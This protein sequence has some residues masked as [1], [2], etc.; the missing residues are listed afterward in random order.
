VDRSQTISYISTL[1]LD[2]ACFILLQLKVEEDYQPDRFW[3]VYN[4]NPSVIEP[5]ITDLEELVEGIYTHPR[6]R[7]VGTEPLFAL[8]SL[9]HMRQFHFLPRD[10]YHLATMRH[11]GV[12]SIVTLD[13]DFLVVPELHIYTC[14]PSIL[15][16]ASRP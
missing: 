6:I 5:Y 16:Q 7:L 8:E 11:Y 14:V 12:D 9:I 15:R 10:A 2:E 3:P 1:A 13:A 4:A